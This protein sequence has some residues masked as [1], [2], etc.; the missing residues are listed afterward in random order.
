MKAPPPRRLILVEGTDDLHVLMALFE[1]HGI[2]ETFQVEH[3][4]DS[5]GFPSQRE[6]F[7][8]RLRGSDL[9]RIGIVI[10]ADQ[11]VAARW[12]SV[13]GIL[14]S[15]GCKHLPPLPDSHGTITQV[16]DGPIVGVWIM[17]DNSNAGILE[18]FLHQMA[19][20]SDPLWQ[21]VDAF[22]DGIPEEHAKCPAIRLPKAR[23]HAWLSVQEEPGKPLGLAIKSKYLDAKSPATEPFLQWIRKLMVD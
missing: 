14:T 13:L 10:D 1:S 17:P 6:K 15:V 23:I 20:Q 2:P 21:L 5:G 4:K 19:P 9:Q 7:T 12:N 16:P 3:P 8:V 18:D 22:I 11:D